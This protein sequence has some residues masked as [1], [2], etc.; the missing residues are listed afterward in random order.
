MDEAGAVKGVRLGD[1]GRAKDGSAGPNFT[2]GADI[3]AGIT[4]L[5]EGCRGS[6]SKQLIARYKLDANCSAPTFALGFKELWQLP[7]GRGSP[8][9]VQHTIGWPLPSATY[10]GSFVYHLDNDRAY[11]G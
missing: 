1:M 5:A 4:I 6:I 2:A 8:G 9:L 10:G 11:V 7:A 3:H